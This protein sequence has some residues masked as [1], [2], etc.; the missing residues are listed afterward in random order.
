[1]A[2]GLYDTAQ[3]L[4]DCVC[5]ALSAAGRPV[6]KC[7][8]SFATPF[9]RSCCECDTDGTNGE[10]SVHFRRMFDADASSLIEVQRVRPC[11]GGVVAAQF[12]LVLARCAPVLDERGELPPV[13]DLE[14]TAEGQ[15]MDLEMFWT[16][17]TCCTGL[18]LRV[19]DVSTDPIP[20]GGCSLVF[21]DVTVAVRPA[22]VPE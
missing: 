7:Y 9:I 21:A 13:E 10:L 18:E 1:M 11:K 5:D 4:L 8:R 22:G 15:M 16:A 19:D 14:D 17:L 2:D 6:C 12:R 20:T 3:T